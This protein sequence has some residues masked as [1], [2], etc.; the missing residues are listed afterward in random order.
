MADLLKSLN[1]Y[2][3]RVSFYEFQDHFA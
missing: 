3:F 2:S 1:F